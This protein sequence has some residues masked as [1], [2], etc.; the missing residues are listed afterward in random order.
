MIILFALLAV[1][2]LAMDQPKYTPSEAARRAESLVGKS[3]SEYVCNQVVNY[4]YYGVK[5]YGYLADAY[6]R[7]GSES[8]SFRAGCA[9]VASTGEHVGIVAN[10]G[11]FIHSSSSKYAVIKVPTSQIKYIFP[12]G[13]HIRCY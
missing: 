7:F 9:V 13:Y 11:N 4:A 6:L 10:D 2:V 5:N 3:R 1:F 12:K 8:S